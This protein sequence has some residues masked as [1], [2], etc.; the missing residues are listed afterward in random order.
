MKVVIVGGGIGGLTAALAFQHFG[1]DVELLEKSPHITGIGAGI[2]ISPNGMKVFA[3]LGLA[4]EIIRRGFQPR[5]LEM[6]F[7]RSGR[8]I[9]K[10]PITE[11]GPK[12]WHASYVHIHRA[13]LINCLSEA[14]RQ[15]AGDCIQLDATLAQSRQ[16]DRAATAEL[17]DGRAF[18]GDILVGADGIHSALRTQMF[19]AASPDFTGN[20]AWR[21]VV[22][23]KKLGRWTPPDTACIWTGP[24]RHAVTYLLRNGEL[25]NF[26]GVVEYDQWRHESWTERGSRDDAL[27]DFAGWHPVITNLISTADEH[28]RWALFDRAPLP[29]WHRGRTVLI[30]D[31]CHPTLPFMAQGAVM[32]IEDAYLLAYLCNMSRTD[33]QHALATFYR[34]RIERTSRIQAGSRANMSTFHK[35]TILGQATSY[36]PMWLAGK[37]LPDLIYARQDPIYGYDITKQA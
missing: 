19:G 36:G 13:D 23:V 15:R 8:Q 6:K 2:Q 27:S 18:H 21:A 22:P 31:A 25:A 28:F 1:W 16:N 12:R 32:A 24:G 9:F 11:E 3:R 35:R 29:Q 5:A 26:V 7:G 10:V 37:L 30:G 17:T 14:L 4:D 34:S 20:I 33:P